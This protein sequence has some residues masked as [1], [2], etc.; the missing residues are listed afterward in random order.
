MQ[1]HLLLTGTT[2]ILVGLVLDL[3]KRTGRVYVRA[4]AHLEAI[5][6]TRVVASIHGEVVGV[7]VERAVA[8]EALARH[9]QHGI[10]AGQRGQD[11]R[12]HAAWQHILHLDPFEQGH[13]L[14]LAQSNGAVV[15]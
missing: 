6:R 13:A 11:G 3:Q 1:R 14:H 2:L 4:G 10:V 8:I 9:L 15:L 12:Q 5:G 7:E